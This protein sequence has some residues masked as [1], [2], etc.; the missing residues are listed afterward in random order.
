MKSYEAYAIEKQ[1]IDE[2]VEEHIEDVHQQYETVKTILCDIA[3]DGYYEGF[4]DGSD[5]YRSSIDD[6]VTAL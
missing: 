3:F 5:W 4:G 2:I 1:K 6:V